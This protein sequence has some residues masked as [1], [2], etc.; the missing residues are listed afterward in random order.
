MNWFPIQGEGQGVCRGWAGRVAKWSA[1][2]LVVPSAGARTCPA[3]APDFLFLLPA[4]Q[5]WQLC[6]GVFFTLLLLLSLH[7]SHVRLFDLTDC[8]PPGS[9]V[10]GI[11]QA[12]P[13]GVY[14][15]LLL[16]PYPFCFAARGDIHL[17]TSTTAKGPGPRAQ[18]VSSVLQGLPTCLSRTVAPGKR[19]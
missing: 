2:P 16:V 18:S 12:S 1:H 15:L 19:Q 7:F 11:S 6:V 3:L 8:S 17:S 14:T 10:R 13:N 4:L 5:K 9:A